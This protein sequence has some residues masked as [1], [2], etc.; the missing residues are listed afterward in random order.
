M[1]MVVE[2]CVDLTSGA[3]ELVTAVAREKNVS[4]AEAMRRLLSYGKF[5]YE[6]LGKGHKI[7]V[8]NAKGPGLWR[9]TFAED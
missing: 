5:V 4:E 1:E 7:L 3:V 6:E 8:E 9:V 2:V